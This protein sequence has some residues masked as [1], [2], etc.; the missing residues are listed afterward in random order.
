M[1]HPSPRDQA[2]GLVLAVLGVLILTPDTL[3]MRLVGAE[4]WTTLFWRGAMMTVGFVL[5]ALVWY[6][7]R[8]VAAIRAIGGLGLLISVI[9]TCNTVFFVVSISLTSVANTLIIVALAPLFAAVIGIAA[10][11]EPVRPRTW[12]AIAVAFA[13]IAVIFADG[14]RTGALVGDLAAVGTAVGLAAHFVLVRAARPVDMTPAVG[15]SGITTAL[16]GLVGAHSLALPPEG[17]LMMAG[18]GI[19]ILPL[20]FAMITL[21]P[22]YIPAAEVSL[23][24]LLETVLGPLWVWL[25]LAED[26]GP[27]TL[28]GGGVVLA[29]LLLHSALSLRAS[30]QQRRAAAPAL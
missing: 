8:T 15:L 28:I 2:K 5:L 24:L 11:G 16:A 23:V 30:R 29:A 1:T 3:I 27:R 13:G 14:W 21:A 20:S 7:G 10:L 26:P 19:L 12:L 18:L 25:A 4:P 9:W 22:L 17:V 6:R